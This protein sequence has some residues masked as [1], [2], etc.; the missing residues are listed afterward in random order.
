MYSTKGD[1]D[2]NQ[3]A[4]EHFNGG[5]HVNAAGGKSD[6]SLAATVDLFKALVVNLNSDLE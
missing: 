2:V 4:R 3:I 6:L 5:G 1:I